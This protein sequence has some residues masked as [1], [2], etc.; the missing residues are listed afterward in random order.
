VVDNGD[1]LAATNLAHNIVTT[2]CQL[3][4]RLPGFEVPA[5]VP[6]SVM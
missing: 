2:A 6:V 5:V 4:D 1:N 3:R